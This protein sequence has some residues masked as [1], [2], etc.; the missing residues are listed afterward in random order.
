MDLEILHRDDWILVVN[1]PPDLLA[2][3]GRG[4]AKQDC[5]VTR[6]RAMF[7]ELID[8]PAVHRL[9]QQTSGLMVLACNQ[10]AHRRL[11]RQ[12]ESRRVTKRYVAIVAKLIDSD[13]GTIAL[14]L[15][16]DPDNRP[17]QVYDPVN[18]REAITHWRKIAGNSRTSRI[19]FTPLTGRTH[20]LRVHSA[21]RWGLGAPIIGDRLY[22]SG[23][24]GEVMLLHA[25]FLSFSHP[26]S[27]L[28]VQ[29][30]SAPQF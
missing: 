21:S 1:K 9:D 25:T 10:E 23:K 27:G 15:R 4:P 13:D 19:E 12:F 6:A 2:V 5:V 18:G 24:K 8:Q 16:L 22:G 20:Q 3:P 14:P 17:Y 11:S 28:P 29:F 30:N 26:G 7:P